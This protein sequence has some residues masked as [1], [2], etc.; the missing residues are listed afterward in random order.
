MCA[1]EKGIEQLMRTAKL[2]TTHKPR[3][4]TTD[5]GKCKDKQSFRT[6]MGY[7][8]VTYR[9]TFITIN[10][11]LAKH[12][13]LGIIMKQCNP[14]IMNINR[15]HTTILNNIMIIIHDEHGEL[16]KDLSTLGTQQQDAHDTRLIQVDKYRWHH[17]T[18]NIGKYAPTLTQSIA[19]H[20][21]DTSHA[22]SVL[23]VTINTPH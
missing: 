15:P 9:G 1:L 11:T 12:S 2:V 17:T 20:M 10:S 7:E 22:T 6:H 21:I 14:T 23:A 19:S 4:H 16:S 18:P 5:M 13:T 8:G 3:P